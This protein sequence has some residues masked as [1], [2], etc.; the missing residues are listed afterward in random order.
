MKC[1]IMEQKESAKNDPC[2]QQKSV[3]VMTENRREEKIIDAWKIFWGKN[4][5]PTLTTNQK[6]LLQYREEKS[7]RATAIKIER[8]KLLEKLL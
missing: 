8:G 3:T 4:N 2:V 5:P 7:Y 6:T 1:R